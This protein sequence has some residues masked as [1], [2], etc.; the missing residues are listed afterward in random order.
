MNADS[1]KRHPLSKSDCPSNDS[2]K[3]DDERYP[4]RKLIGSLMFVYCWGRPDIGVALSICARY[5]DNP[6]KRHWDAARNILKYLKATQYHCIRFTRNARHNHELTGYVDAD[7]MSGDPDTS[8]SRTGYVFFACGGPV[9]WRSTL[10]SLTAQ[11]TAESELVALNAIA[12]ECEWLRVLYH[13]LFSGKFDH[14]QNPATQVWEDNQAAKAIA[15]NCIMT[16]RNRHF[17]VRLFYVRDQIRDGVLRVDYIK[18]QDNI[19]DG[20]TKVLG[21]ILFRAFRDAVVFLPMSRS[22]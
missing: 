14:L 22:A 7:Y 16:K 17:R 12:K 11:S 10:Q 19:A 1:Q 15:E 13:E 9:V 18:S 20:L 6:G 8:R 4:Y 5:Q 21:R 3:L 2:D